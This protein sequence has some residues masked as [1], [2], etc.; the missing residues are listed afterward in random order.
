M[1]SSKGG[2]KP[3]ILR[4]KEEKEQ[5]AGPSATGTGP[6]PTTSERSEAAKTVEERKD[7]ASGVV[8]PNVDENG[9]PKGEGS[10]VKNSSSSG[11]GS[12][13]GAEEILG[14]RLN[15][16]DNLSLQSCLR[17]KKNELN[18]LSGVIMSRQPTM[19]I[20]V[21]G[22]L[23]HGKSTLVKLLSTVNPPRFRTERAKSATIKLCYANAKIFKALSDNEKS[24]LKK[25]EPIT[26]QEK[27]QEKEKEPKKD[28]ESSIEK[29]SS[30]TKGSDGAN[31]I[32][33]KKGCKRPEC[34]KSF[35]SDKCDLFALSRH[36]TPRQ[37][38]R[39]SN[40][41]T[42]DAISATKMSCSS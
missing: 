20:G 10:N 2:W 12:I 22:S 6:T 32:S 8:V 29:S 40:Q 25:K 9:P 27:E 7:G 26:E 31:A 24:K 41:T 3:S 23:S 13:K 34:F 11:G 21:L 38:T 30:T 35:G 28:D 18:T 17:L 1:S 19:T 33:S 14:Y 36:T 42:V 37:D 16:D 5:R 4:E 39:D 15:P